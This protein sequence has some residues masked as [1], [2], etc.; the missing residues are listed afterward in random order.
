MIKIA[1][2]HTSSN[3]VINMP[4]DAIIVH[5]KIIDASSMV[6]YAI[7]DTDAPLGERVFTVFNTGQELPENLVTHFSYLSTHLA[8]H[9]F[10]DISKQV[11]LY[12]QLNNDDNCI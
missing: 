10:E 12:R 9:A 5:T 6:I 7:I 3:V 4:Q 1:L 8:Y 2:F 11:E